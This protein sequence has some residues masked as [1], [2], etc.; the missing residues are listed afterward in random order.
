MGRPIGKRNNDT[1]EQALGAVIT[2]LRVKRGLSYQDVAEKVGCND[3]YLHRVETGKTNPTFR[4]MKAIA[5]FHKIKLSRLISLA[6]KKYA[7]RRRSLS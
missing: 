4:L 2:E 3:V 5:D 6:E 7:R 1:P